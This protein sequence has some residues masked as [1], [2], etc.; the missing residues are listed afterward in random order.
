MNDVVGLRAKAYSCLR[1]Q[2]WK[3]TKECVIKKILIFKI[4][5]TA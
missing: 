2:W 5:K 3:G 1:E 4:I